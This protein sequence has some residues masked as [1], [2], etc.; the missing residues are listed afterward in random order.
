MKKAFIVLIIAIAAVGTVKAQDYKTSLGLRAGVPY[1]VTIKHFL[2]KTDAVEGILAGLYGGFVITG[3]W[4]NEHWT[5]KYPGLNWYWGLGAHVG[6]WDAG[7]NPNLNS[8]YTGAV[9]GVDAVLGLEYT[10][11]DIPINLSLDVLPVVNLIG[12]TGWGGINGAL[13]VRYVF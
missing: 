2:G 10:F 1:G 12:S 6:F 5:G 11:D 3:L 9:I 4:E 7:M 8:T 13:S